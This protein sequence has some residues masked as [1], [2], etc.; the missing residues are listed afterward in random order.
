MLA[1]LLQSPTVPG[2]YSRVTHTSPRYQELQ[3]AGIFATEP[4]CARYLLTTKILP[5]KRSCSLCR[6][7]MEIGNSANYRHPLPYRIMLEVPRCKFATS[8]RVDSVIANTK[9]SYHD[10]IHVTE[11]VAELKFPAEAFANLNLSES[12]VRGFFT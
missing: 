8:I 4:D 1:S 11:A 6:T 12:T 5:T 2:T 3:S 7:H 10:F 9:I